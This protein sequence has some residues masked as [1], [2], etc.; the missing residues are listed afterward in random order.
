MLTIVDYAGTADEDDR[1]A[2]L[3]ANVYVQGCFTDAARAATVFVPSQVRLRGRILL[4]TT[5][6]AAVVGM[7]ICGSHDNP[8]RQVADHEEAEMQLLAVDP[9]A[10]GRGLGR[11]L[12]LAF[13]HKASALGYRKAVLSTQ[14]AMSSAQRVY[15]SLGYRRHSSR[16]WVRENRSFIVYEKSLDDGDAE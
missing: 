12:C 3:L 4:A 14:P 5:P 15:E 8:Y 9:G 16:D 13:E 10:R 11:A 7:V 6:A 2:S 1:V